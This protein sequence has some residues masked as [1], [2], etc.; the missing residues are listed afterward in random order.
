MSSNKP[1]ARRDAELNPRTTKYEFFGPP[2]ALFV[3]L[4]VPITTYALYFGCSEETGGCP[5]PISKETIVAA[6][7][8]PQWWMG[9]WDTEA[10]LLYLG[11]YAFC[12]AAW[13]V[14]PGDWVEGVTMRTGEKKKYKINGERLAR[15]LLSVCSKR[16]AFST[17]LLA[18]GLTIGWIWQNGIESFTFVYDKWVGL[19]TASIVMSVVQGLACYAAS[20]RP[21]A[22]LALGGNSGN[23]IYDVRLPHRLVVLPS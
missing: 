2:G 23:P 15:A 18:L 19:M 16:L 20:F 21:G 12:V 9:L 7:S 5:P 14:L 4:S 11:W 10:A 22:L 3:T 1:V 13:I 17:F 8:D 6:L